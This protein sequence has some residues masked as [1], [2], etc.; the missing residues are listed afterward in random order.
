MTT[1]SGSETEWELLA[2]EVLAELEWTPTSPPA[3]TSAT[4]G[5]TSHCLGACSKPCA[6]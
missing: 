3:A 1:S 2:K 4:P 6:S 5:L